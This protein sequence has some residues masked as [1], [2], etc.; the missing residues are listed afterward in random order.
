MATVGIVGGLGPEA[1]IDYYRRLLAAVSRGVAILPYAWNDAA[2]ADFARAQGAALAGERRRT[3]YSL[4]PQS[5][6]DA[7][8]G[9]RCVLPSPNGA[10]ATIAAAA[11]GA[12]VPA[13]CLWISGGEAAE[14]CDGGSLR[15]VLV[16]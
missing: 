13:G 8:A 11:S 7:P 10:R 2:S 15:R 12:V 14:W 3:R 4:A 9:L 1:T 5:Y 16:R 6:L